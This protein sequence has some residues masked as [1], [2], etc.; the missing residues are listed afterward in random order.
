MILNEIGMLA[1][2]SNRTKF[3]LQQMVK[4]QLL[5]SFVIYLDDSVSVTP[6]AKAIAQVMEEKTSVQHHDA[7]ISLDVTVLELLEGYRIPYQHL[8]TLDPNSDLVVKAVASCSPSI[9]IYSGPGGFILRKPLF[10]VGKR[11]LH[12]HSGILP[13]YRGST[14]LYYSLL[15]EGQCGATALF[16]DERIDTG[17][18]IR[19]RA[20]PAPADRTAIDLHYD[21]LIRSELLAEVLQDYVHHG[22]IP[23]ENQ[24]NKTGETY[25]IIHPVL[26]HIAILAR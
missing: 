9:L 26:K 1:V 5:P 15:K 21:P 19:R 13:Y 7:E 23:S 8:P 4:R 10:E 17:P 22:E 24:D 16:L 14:T 18:V 20:Y 3:Y 2:S 12:I 25:F 11:F 6:E